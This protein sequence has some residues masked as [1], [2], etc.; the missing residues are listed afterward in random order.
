MQKLMI[1]ITAFAAPTSNTE[2]CVCTINAPANA[3]MMIQE[4]M[5]CPEGQ[6]S[7]DP[8]F[9][10]KVGIASGAGTGGTA[11]TPVQLDPTK[12]LGSAITPTAT[13]WGS[14]T[15]STLVSAQDVVSVKASDPLFR[16]YAA[17]PITVKEGTS[18]CITANTLSSTNGNIK[19]SGYAIAWV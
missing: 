4:I 12:S 9:R 14:G 19:F 17:N 16:Q 15:P 3:P 7:T 18:F 10:Y 8:S 6:V 5:L 11:I 1:P 13:Q 2:Y